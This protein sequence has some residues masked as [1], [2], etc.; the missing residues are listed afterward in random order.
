MM[1]NYALSQRQVRT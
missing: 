1:Q